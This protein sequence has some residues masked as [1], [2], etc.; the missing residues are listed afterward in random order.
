MMKVSAGLSEPAPLA[1]KADI[2]RQVIPVDP[3]ENDPHS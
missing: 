2:K 3:V 1:S